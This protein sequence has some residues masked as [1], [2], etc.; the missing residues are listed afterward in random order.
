M[1]PATSCADVGVWVGLIIIVVMLFAGLEVLAL[2]VM[3]VVVDGVKTTVTAGAEDTVV[4][5]MTCMEVCVVTTVAVAR[6]VGR[7][8]TEESV[9]IG[10]SS[11]VDVRMEITRTTLVEIADGDTVEGVWLLVSSGELMVV[12]MSKVVV[13]TDVGRVVIIVVGTA[14]GDEAVI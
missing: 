4:L 7:N 9:G 5:T 13:A 11:S 1:P 10:S 12:E 8:A 3:V 6:S 2:E 14:D